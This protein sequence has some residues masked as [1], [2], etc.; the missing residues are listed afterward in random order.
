MTQ[1][2]AIFYDAYRGLNAKIIFWIVLILSVVAAGGVGC[3]GLNETGVKIAVWQ[4]DHPLINSVEIE[5]ALF[6]KWIFVNVGINYWLALFATILALLSTAGIFPNLI[7]SGSIHLLVSKPIG[8]LRLFLTQYAAG[9]LFV[10]LQVTLF[11]AACFLVIGLRGGAW[12]PGLFVAVP[13]VVCFFSYLFSVCVLLGLITRSAL[14]ALLLTLLFWLFTWAVGTTEIVLLAIEKQ[15]KYGNFPPGAMQ[16]DRPRNRSAPRQPAEVRL[17]ARIAVPEA[18]P[19]RDEDPSALKRG[20]RVPLAVG[21]ALVK[22]VAEPSAPD[23]EKGAKET[24]AATPRAGTFSHPAGKSGQRL[25]DEPR[26]DNKE[27]GSSKL[28]RAHDIAYYIKT[29]LPKTGDTILLLQRSL[30]DMAALPEGA[31]G[32]PHEHQK[33]ERELMETILGR[34]VRWVVGTSLGFEAV[35]LCLAALVFCRRDY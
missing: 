12:E 28:K 4:I 34:S 20:S 1:T 31:L 22:A 24:K 2:L 3:V 10:T 14:A 13:L 23:D 26:E 19:A 16:V 8:R 35:L 9:L 27:G 6:Y 30:F 21:R 11:T 18:H 17:P 7:N 32:Q 15:Q 33:A 5:P 25:A 29:V